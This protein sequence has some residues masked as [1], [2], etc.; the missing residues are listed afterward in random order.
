MKSPELAVSLPDSPTWGVS[1]LIIL[2]W[3]SVMALTQATNRQEGDILPAVLNNF[4]NMDI[5]NHSDTDI[6]TISDDETQS[7]IARETEKITNTC[8]DQET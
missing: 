1:Y 6:S 7:S 4:T 3:I 2:I 8:V 5:D